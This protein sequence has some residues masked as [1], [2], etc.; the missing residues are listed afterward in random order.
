M[1]SYIFWLYNF[2]IS[3][4]AHGYAR[5]PYLRSAAVAHALFVLFL[6]FDSGDPLSNLLMD[7]STKEDA[8]AF[9]KK[10]GMSLAFT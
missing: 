5:R 7:F 8:V 3:L 9:A 2:V 6:D 10:S 1:A 4:G